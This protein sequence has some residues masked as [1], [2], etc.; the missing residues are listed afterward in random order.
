VG[1]SKKPVRVKV[2]NRRLDILNFFLADVRGGLGAFVSVFLLTQAHWTAGEIGAVL[3]ISGLIGITAHTPIGA[4][5]DMT[6]SKRAMLVMGVMVLAVC[7]VAIER[8][9]IGPVVLSAD[10]A[11]AV[12]GAVFA[13]TIAAISLGVVG[14]KRFPG[15]VARNVAFDRLGNVFMAALVGVVGWY[16]S[17][18]AIFYLV[19]FFAFLSAFVVLS[20][21][22]HAIDHDVA[23]GFT[24]ATA[25][26]LPEDWRTMLRE[27]KPLL[28]LALS[29]A[30][31]H[32][33]GATM[34]PLAG[35][36][37]ALEHPG[38][39]T[40]LL[41]ACIL[42]AQLGMIPMALL[43]GA[44]AD[45]WGR[46]PLFVI[47]CAAL[48]ARGFIFCQFDSALVLVGAQVL[49]GISG[50]ILDILVPLMLADIM[51]GSG[52]Y[53]V[54][55]GVVGTVQ[56]VGGSLSNVA[57]GTLVVVGGYNFAFAALAL[58]AAC[59]LCLVIVR[60]PETGRLSMK[61]AA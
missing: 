44:R 15:R 10:I 39:E 53:S 57:G 48:V 20:I 12:L 28:L 59:A 26:R 56:G 60:M 45:R 22:A 37:L 31:F 32:F 36:K 52:R 7:A 16:F 34:L 25:K 41:S 55:R 14:P 33:A 58:A 38:F 54:S 9:P 30:A 1:H 4:L 47:A 50:G 42:V 35:Q 43:V 23:R 40:L 18:H 6:R 24:A 11:M 51:R 49:D 5:I 27:R 8:T 21:P 3:T 61:G 2:H 13:P 29:V 19:P 17:Q 46:K